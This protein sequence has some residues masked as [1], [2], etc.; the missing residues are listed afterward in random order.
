MLAMFRVCTIGQ[1]DLLLHMA[2]EFT[3]SQ[4]D[5]I[6]DNVVQ[7]RASPPLVA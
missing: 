2:H 4:N 6:P 1:Q 7:L 3:G 5:E